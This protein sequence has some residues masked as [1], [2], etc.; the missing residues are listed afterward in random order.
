[1]L[2]L[3]VRL[4]CAASMLSWA[5]LSN[6]AGVASSALAQGDLEKPEVVRSWLESNRNAPR[7]D[8]QAFRV[9][10][11][12]ARA[13]GR[14]GA[15]AKGYAEAALVYP[16]PELL[17]A[18]AET[19]LRD[20]IAVSARSSAPTAS[21]RRT[22]WERGAAILRAALAADDVLRSLAPAQR[23]DL[24]AN[25]DC[26]AAAARSGQMVTTCTLLRTNDPASR[27]R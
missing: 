22:D 20:R 23:R 2:R 27:A 26:L 17:R 5:S 15:A 1:M 24:V 4:L 10:A 16:T 6:A 8:A 7:S 18:Y 19:L 12:R 25:S 9:A 3:W 11:E 14:W 21:V 13:S